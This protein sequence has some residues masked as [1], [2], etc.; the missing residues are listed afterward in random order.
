MKKL[1]SLLI[2]LPLMALSPLTVADDD[3]DLEEVTVDVEEEKP[4]KARR[5]QT[6]GNN[7]ILEYM[8]EKGD[9]TQE[10]I[11]A[12]QAERKAVRDELTALK[13]AGDKEALQAKVAQL[14]EARKAQRE[15]M[16]QYVESH[17]ELAAALNEQKEQLKEQRQE[18]KEEQ[19]AK[20]EQRQAKKEER[21]AQKEERQEKREERREKREERKKK[22]GKDT[23]GEG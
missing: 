14:R 15:E 22:K 1:L 8:L 2:A 11:E 7:L 12:R 5:P 21:Q 13:Q 20:K 10:E 18:R 9:I 23:D 17:E 19:Q 16:K 6:D 4:E 3:I